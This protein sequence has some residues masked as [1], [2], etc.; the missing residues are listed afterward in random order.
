MLTLSVHVNN[1]NSY[2]MCLH[3]ATS[4]SCSASHRYNYSTTFLNHPPSLHTPLIVASSE[5]YVTVCTEKEKIVTSSV[6]KSTEPEWNFISE[7]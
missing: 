7:M 6:P 3:V 1:T 5:L 4:N 2:S